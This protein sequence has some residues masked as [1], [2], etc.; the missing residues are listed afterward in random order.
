MCSLMVK[1]ATTARPDTAAGA[2]S[3]E[4][5]YGHTELGG[6]RSSPHSV[7][8]W[9]R[10]TPSSPDFQKNSLFSVSSGSNRPDGSATVTSFVGARFGEVGTLPGLPRSHYFRAL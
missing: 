7:Q 10:R 1:P 6:W 2:H 8:R 3:S 4:W 9:K 5:Q